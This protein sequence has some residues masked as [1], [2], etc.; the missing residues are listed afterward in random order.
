MWL[1]TV[2]GIVGLIRP[3][4]VPGGP[5][6]NINRIQLQPLRGAAFADPNIVLGG[7][8]L[9]NVPTPPYNAGT[10]V[11]YI[12]SIV[13]DIRRINVI[14]P[15]P[16]VD[17][18]SSVIKTF[19]DLLRDAPV[20]E[21][22]SKALDLVA[23]GGYEAFISWIENLTDRGAFQEA[24]DIIADRHV[25]LGVWPQNYSRFEA[26]ISQYTPAARFTPQWLKI[27]I[28]DLLS[29][30]EY[31]GR[32]EQVPFLVG[33]W[34]VREINNFEQN[35]RNFASRCYFNKYGVAGSLQQRFQGSKR[36]LYYWETFEPGYWEV[37]TNYRPPDPLPSPLS[38]DLLQD[39]SPR[40]DGIRFSTNPLLGHPFNQGLNDFGAG[41]CAVDFV[42]NFA[43]ENTYDRLPFILYSPNLRDST[44]EAAAL[45][46]L[47]W[48]DNIGIFRT[49]EINSLAEMSTAERIKAILNNHRY[50]SRFNFIWNRA[51]TPRPELPDWKYLPWFGYFNDKTFPWTFHETLGWI[52]IVGV[53][54]ERFWFHQED[55]GWVWTGENMFPWLYSQ[56]DGW[57]NYQKDSENPR[58]FYFMNKG[59]WEER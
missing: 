10:A 53:Q 4:L 49:N 9:G 41:E 20:G 12:P 52:Y 45:M 33:S 18:R 32:F 25:A 16:W 5:L 44:Y 37:Q 47:L 38:L 35:R 46:A 24:V 11:P 34:L 2:P 17:S 22:I 23:E 40:R 36:M 48:K 26:S 15:M 6:L 51:A 28:D 54:T 43:R 57:I 3:P 58:R 8:G 39:S 7:I 13:S 55:L 30:N 1:E 29:S 59:A 56:Q 50:T 42:W 14:P 31:R 21:E 27:Y 19:N